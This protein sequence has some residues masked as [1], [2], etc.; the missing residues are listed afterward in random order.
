MMFALQTLH[1]ESERQAQD[2]AVAD[3]APVSIAPVKGSQM[4]T[5][6]FAG[7][8]VRSEICYYRSAGRG[9]RCCFVTRPLPAACCAAPLFVSADWQQ[10][11]APHLRL[12]S[13]SRHDSARRHHSERCVHGWCCSVSDAE[14][15]AQSSVIQ[16]VHSLAVVYLSHKRTA[17]VQWRRRRSRS[18]QA[19]RSPSS[20]KTRAQRSGRSAR[21]AASGNATSSKP[22]MRC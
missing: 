4:S 17:R 12:S 9:R 16:A 10:Q 11:S 5:C 13:C 20:R 15:A 7:N 1:A 19:A 14:E 18:R 22:P 3:R 6:A 2:T 8:F 21:S